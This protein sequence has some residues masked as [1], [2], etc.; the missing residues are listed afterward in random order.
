MSRSPISSRRARAACRLRRRF[1][2][3]GRLRRGGDC[4]ALQGGRRRLFGHH[5]Q[6]A[7]RPPGRS[8]CRAPAPARAQGILGLCRGRKLASADLIAE[9]YQGIRP[10][11]GYPAQPDH[12]EKATLFAL[13]DAGTAIGISSPKALPCGRA[14][15]SAA[16]ISAIP[17]VTISGW[18]KSSAIRSRTMRGARAGTCPMRSGGSRRCSITTRLRR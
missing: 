14:H 4:G 3:H 8:V 10:A 2:G 18:A 15:P 13:L 7:G 5:G 16:S 11:P 12:T 6:G 9:K 1:P 17:K